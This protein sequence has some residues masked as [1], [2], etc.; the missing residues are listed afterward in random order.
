MAGYP[1]KQEA[2]VCDM[3]VGLVSQICVG[4]VRLWVCLCIKPRARHRNFKTS[5]L[6]C[7]RHDELSVLAFGEKISW[8]AVLKHDACVFGVWTLKC[9][10]RLVVWSCQLRDKSVIF[11]LRVSNSGTNTPAVMG[12]LTDQFPKLVEPVTTLSDPINPEHEACVP[13]SWF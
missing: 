13:I 10:W 3:C 8:Q 1:F 2:T 5:Y 6:A 9:I 4:V 11:Q 12:R 7:S